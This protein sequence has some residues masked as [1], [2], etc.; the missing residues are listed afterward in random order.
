[1]AAQQPLILW[2]PTVHWRNEPGPPPGKG[3]LLDVGKDARLEAICPWSIMGEEKRRAGGW[4]QRI[5]EI[6]RPG[7]DK[8]SQ[9]QTASWES[10]EREKMWEWRR[11]HGGCERWPWL[12]WGWTRGWCRGPWWLVAAN[13]ASPGGR[14]PCRAPCTAPSPLPSLRHEET[15]SNWHPSTQIGPWHNLNSHNSVMK[16]YK[17]ISQHLN[18]LNTSLFMVIKINVKLAQRHFLG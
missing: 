2:W 18:I 7:E 3:W 10:D 9:S 8:E 14:A 5:R 16:N 1:M 13:Q 11:K 17:L 4:W 15:P 6:Q 12:M